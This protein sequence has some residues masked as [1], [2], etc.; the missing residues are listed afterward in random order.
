MKIRMLLAAAALSVTP[1]PALAQGAPAAIHVGATVTD[2]A[3]GTVGTITAV[4]GATVTLRTDKHEVPI[5][6]GSF[7]TSGTQV[8]FGMTRDQLNAAIEQASAASQAA[9]AVGAQ[10]H[11]RD[12]ALV[13]TVAALDADVVTVQMD[14]Q[15]IRLPRAA[16]A[17]SANG[18]VTG[19]TIAELRAATA[20][21]P[22]AH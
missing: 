5:P 9:F 19:A 7:A 21:A 16:L 18:L 8:V 20:P 6:V 22:A 15:R 17:G 3:G 11:D 4:N 14:T 13:G 2:T 12:G 1:L 10:V